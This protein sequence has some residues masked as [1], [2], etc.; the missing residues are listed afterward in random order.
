MGIL[1]EL[2]D[3]INGIACGSTRTKLW[4]ADI[5]GIGTMVNSGNA[6]GQVACRS[7]QFK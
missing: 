7:Q 1:S 3:V 6:T 2:T 5:Y 4:C